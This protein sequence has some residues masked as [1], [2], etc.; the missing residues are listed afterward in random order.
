[1][2]ISVSDLDVKFL[3]YGGIL[4][5]P[6][7]FA[8]TIN[9]ASHPA[10]GQKATIRCDC[11]V[12][13]LAVHPR[14]TTARIHHVIEPTVKREACAKDIVIK[15]AAP[16]LV[17]CITVAI[18]TPRVGEDWVERL[19]KRILQPPEDGLEDSERISKG[20]LVGP[21][22]F[23]GVFGEGY[24]ALP[25]GIAGATTMSRPSRPWRWRWPDTS[26]IICLLNDE[27]CQK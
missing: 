17:I 21:A 8:D 18:S 14:A 7:R 12:G 4:A 25:A 13:H 1:M 22:K 3:T 19:V 24:V 27:K 15:E 16:T 20:G 11:A 6:N 26:G 10:L 9:R 5:F 23:E 2:C